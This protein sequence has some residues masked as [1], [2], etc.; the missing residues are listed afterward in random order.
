MTAY[1]V[2]AKLFTPSHHFPLFT[3]SFPFYHRTGWA[4]VSNSLIYIISFHIELSP[5]DFSVLSVF[6]SAF[7]EAN[8]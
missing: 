7:R 2:S 4:F 1:V 3:F 6:V 8:D 5:W